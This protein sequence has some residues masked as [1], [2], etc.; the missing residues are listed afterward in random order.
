[1]ITFSNPRK[2]DIKNLPREDLFLLLKTHPEPFNGP[3][4]EYINSDPTALSCKYP[5]TPLNKFYIKL[6]S[7][8]GDQEP[9]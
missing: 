2:K 4:D 5:L 7:I 8:N 3:W 1:M 6:Q 9:I